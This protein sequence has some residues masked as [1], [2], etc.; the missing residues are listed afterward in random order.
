MIQS[1]YI[2]DTMTLSRYYDTEY[3]QSR[4]YDTEYIQSRYYDTE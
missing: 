3:I 1:I 2:V 4:Y